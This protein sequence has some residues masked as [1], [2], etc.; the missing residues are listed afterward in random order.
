MSKS[1]HQYLN[2]ATAKKPEINASNAH[3]LVPLEI[4][5]IAMDKLR[6]DL[7]KTKNK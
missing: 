6:N 3:N 4:V 7:L 1:N 2:E 5:L